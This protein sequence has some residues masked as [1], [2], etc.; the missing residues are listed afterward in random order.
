MTEFG[1]VSDRVSDYKGEC[2]EASIKKGVL[3]NECEWVGV[4]GV[5]ACERELSS[6]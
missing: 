1:V 4:R 5:Y 2:D 3:V 6:D